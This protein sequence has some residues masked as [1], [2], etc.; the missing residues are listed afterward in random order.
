MIEFTHTI[1]SSE[2]L[3]FDGR[4]DVTYTQVHNATQLF[5][6]TLNNWFINNEVVAGRRVLVRFDPNK[7][8][9]G[10]SAIQLIP[11]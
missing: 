11:Q 6:G 2:A 9:K 3:V 7:R 5:N 10:I 4:G 1:T 8:Y